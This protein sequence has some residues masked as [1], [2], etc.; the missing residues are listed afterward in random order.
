[1][2]SQDTRGQQRRLLGIGDDGI[3]SDAWGRQ[4]VVHDK[5]LFSATFSFS[6]ALG[7]WIEY[8]D[9]VEQLVKN[10][11]SIVNGELVISSNGGST[12]LMSRRNPKYQGNR[13]HLYSNSVI[14]KDAT[15][16][17]GKMYAVVRTF[18]DSTVIE[19]RDQIIHKDLFTNVHHPGKGCTYDIQ[20]QLRDVGNTKFYINQ[21][22]LYF[23]DFLGKLDNLVLS[24]MS[25][26]LS[27]ECTNEGV[28]RFGFFTPQCGIFFEWVFDTPQETELISGCVD[29]STEGGEYQR[30]EFASA[31]GNE[32]TATNC[33]VL[34]VRVPES[35]D[36]VINTIDA[37]LAR[38]KAT[39]SKKATL[40]VWITR[41]PTALTIN[42]G[43][44]TNINGGN[45]QQYAPLLAADSSLD[46]NKAQLV[47]V[48]PVQ[49]NINNLE[50]N[51]A[52]EKIDFY[53][54]HGDYLILTINGT[55]VDTQAFIQMGDE[56]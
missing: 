28:I 29:L 20:S 21:F 48:I 56:I 44:W 17:N 2:F 27:F 1:M 14:I 34:A 25:N 4:K 26:P 7:R 52:R 35:I 13:G 40:D 49:A 31:I 47:S 55:S 9:G 6:A 18:R 51:P 22:E 16:E 8:N 43:T 41:D 46:T 42:A 19:S 45:L 5:S 54:V 37:E 23:K 50:D 53:L 38:I 32:F 3:Y 33:P 11:A 24:N 30:Q 15:H 10:N 12:F 36:G 39:V